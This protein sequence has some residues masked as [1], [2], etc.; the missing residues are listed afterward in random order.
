MAEV[1]SIIPGHYV[2]TFK[3]QISSETAGQHITRTH[4][5]VLQRATQIPGSTFH[6]VNHR[7]DFSGFAGYSGSFDDVT[8]GE[9]R[10]SSEVAIVEPDRLFYTL[11]DTLHTQEN[12]PS[13]GLS[14]ICRDKAVGGATTYVYPSANG[15]NTH[16][17][18]ID[19]GIYIEHDEFNND[20]VRRARWGTTI[21]S[22]GAKDQD[23][24]GHGTHVAGTIAGQQCGVAK[25]AEVIAVKVFKDLTDQERRDGKHTSASNSDI[26]KAV[27]WSVKDAGSKIRRSVINMSLRS[28]KSEA[29]NKAIRSAVSAG[30]AVVVASGND[31][32]DAINYSPASAFEAIT[33]GA[34]DRDDKNYVNSNYG[35]CVDVLAPGVD[36]KSA[37]IGGVSELVVMTGTS[38]AAPHVTGVVCCIFTSDPD[39][40]TQSPATAIQT[41][42]KVAGRDEITLANQK[43]TLNLMLNNGFHVK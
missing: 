13:W 35:K 11:K 18:V 25:K 40:P 6:G 32:K 10:I 7:Y 1:D 3:P 31:G 19:T 12:V 24:E 5:I 14:R 42:K 30:M 8:V 17:Y 38:M 26:I 36:I 4:D 33:V 37:G 23:F 21:V 16:A 2:V 27:E 29:L 22:K 34:T 20:N 9:L 15:Q 39:D 41:V 43:D 28:G